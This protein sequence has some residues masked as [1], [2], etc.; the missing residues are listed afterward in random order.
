MGEKKKKSLLNDSDKVVNYVHLCS[1]N[2]KCI[3]CNLIFWSDFSQKYQFNLSLGSL[4]NNTIEINLHN[5][6]VS[7]SVQ[8]ANELLDVGKIVMNFTFSPSEKH[9]ATVFMIHLT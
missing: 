6:A 9:H 3:Q 7:Y 4:S 2:S 1:N 8:S 5:Y